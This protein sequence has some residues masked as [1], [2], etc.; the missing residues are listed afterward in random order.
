MSTLR[1]PHPTSRGRRRRSAAMLSAVLLTTFLQGCV[2][3]TLTDDGEF[4]RIP[5]ARIIDDPKLLLG[6]PSEEDELP[7]IAQGGQPR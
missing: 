1:N 4:K 6:L 7:V 2:V 5:T 3:V